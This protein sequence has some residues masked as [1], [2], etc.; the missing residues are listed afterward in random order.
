MSNLDD[1]IQYGV[2]IPSSGTS[3]EQKLIYQSPA[4]LYAASRVAIESQKIT[5]SSKI[6]T[7][8]NPNHAAGLLAQTLPA[9]YIGAEFKLV[10][11]NAF[12]FF[13][14][15]EDCTHTMATP[16]HLKLI[17]A[18][19]QFKDCDLSGLFLLTG[20]DPVEWY[21]IEEFVKKGAI[22]CPNWGMT[23]IGPICINKTF[24]NI[25]QVLEEKSKSVDYATI[26]GDTFYCDYKIVDNELFVKGD[27][28][29]YDDWYGTGDI[30]S[31][32]N[33]TLYYHGRKGM[34]INLYDSKK[35]L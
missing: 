27:I 11:F 13:K 31:D 1:I 20:A 5:K 22:V 21:L 12:R 17:M 28:C 2:S 24:Y 7:I 25:D 15:I 33:N 3:G 4:K 23:E 34:N 14:D 8:C 19:K 16:L 18:T 35:G 26:L 9:Y 30:V 29:V 6:L 32:H 10:Q